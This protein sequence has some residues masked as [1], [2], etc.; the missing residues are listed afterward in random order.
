VDALDAAG[1]DGLKDRL[2]SRISQLTTIGFMI[3]SIGGAYIADIDIA[4]PWLCG[5][6]GYL[7]AAVIGVCLM[8]GEK[9]RASGVDLAGMPQQIVVRVVEG[10]RSGLSNRTVMMLSAAGAIQIAAWSPYW[11]EWPILFHEGFGVGVWIIGWIYCGLAIARMIG[12]EVVSRMSSDEMARPGRVS[13]LIGMAGIMLAAAGVF[14][15][16]PTVAL[17]FLF[18]M[19]ICTGAV[20][21]MLQSWFNEQIDS[22]Q[23][24]T[25]LSFQ[26]T[27]GTMGG[28]IGLFINGFIADRAG[29][30]SAWQFAGALTLGAI[31]CYLAIRPRL[32]RIEMAEPVAK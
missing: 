14:Q 1:Y 21:P 9:P 18:V 31:P 2:F 4:Y 11:L 20:T 17:T 23:R 28:S 30:A 12:A 26:S 6:A 10:V 8:N 3:S 13:A 32:A 24:A 7:V 5:A 29:L 25:M 22:S 15:M 19:N 27:F 16:R